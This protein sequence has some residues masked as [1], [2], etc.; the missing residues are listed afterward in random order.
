[1]KCERCN[2]D[3]P[4]A[5]L[6][7]DVKGSRLLCGNCFSFVKSGSLVPQKVK[8]DAGKDFTETRKRLALSTSERLDKMGKQKE[9]Y[10][11]KSCNYKF[12]HSP[13]FIG[14]CPY[15][16]APAVMPYAQEVK[17]KEIDDLF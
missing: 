2:G 9:Q 17:L 13:G 5:Q 6:R 4:N 10:Q 16:A 14:K 11:C 15:C 12:V 3:F 8:E 1:M 7:V